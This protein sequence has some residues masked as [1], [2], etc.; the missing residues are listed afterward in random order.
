L[1]KG[2]KL[3]IPAETAAMA[4]GYHVYRSGFTVEISVENMRHFKKCIKL[5]RLQV[6]MSYRRVPAL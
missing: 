2:L 3:A 6:G 4:V 1:D 5:E